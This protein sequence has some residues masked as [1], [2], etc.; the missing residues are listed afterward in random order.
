MAGISL[1][2]AGGR[3]VAWP[4]APIAAFLSLGAGFV[5]LA[6]TSS[7]WQDWWA[8]GLFF[9]ATGV[10]QVLFAPLVLRW[11]SPWLILAGVVGNLAIVGMYILSRTEGIPLGPHTGVSELATPIDLATT[12]GEIVLAAVLL[13]MLAPGVRRWAFNG[14]LVAGVSLWVLRVVGVLN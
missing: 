2:P 5:H 7:H 13:T 6:Y 10:L 14:L 3:V 12:A 1:A 4:A 8:Y 9:L 11:P